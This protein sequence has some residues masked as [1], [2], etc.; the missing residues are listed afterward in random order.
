MKNT[1]LKRILCTTLALLALVLLLPSNAVALSSGSSGDSIIVD[2]EDLFGPT[3]SEGLTFESNGDG[4]YGVSGI[5]SCQDTRIVIPS[6]YSGASVTTVRSGAFAGVTEITEVVFPNTLTT[7]A[8]NAFSGCS[9]LTK[10][11]LPESLTTIASRAFEGC[12]GVSVLYIP[13]KVSSIHQY[14][15]LNCSG[16]TAITANPTNG[17]YYATANCLIERASKV[18]VLGCKNSVIPA[19]GSVTVIGPSAFY[20]RTGMTALNIPSTVTQIGSSAFRNCTDLTTVTFAETISTIS[21]NAFGGCTAITDVYY[22]GTATAWANNVNVVS[23]NTDLT[24]ATMHFIILVGDLNLDDAVDADDVSYLRHYMAGW[25]DYTLTDA[26]VA[27]FNDD[28]VV[29]AIDV[30]LLSRYVA[31]W[32]NV[33]LK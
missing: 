28:G 19:D 20:G 31:G 14:A 24:D 22:N 33:E 10:L 16:L 2:W 26:T 4:T 25:S 30:A 11:E 18:L 1:F 17:V 23:G 12:S 7:I 9:G 6:T 32:E 21:V 5:G 27:D 15:F 13:A 8:A 3:P 29:N